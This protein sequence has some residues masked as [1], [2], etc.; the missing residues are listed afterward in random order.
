MYC[1][2][3][4]KRVLNV[5]HARTPE[6]LLTCQALRHLSVAAQACPHQQPQRLVAVVLCWGGPCVSTHA[7]CRPHSE[8]LLEPSQ[9]PP[10]G[11]AACMRRPCHRPDSLHPTLCIVR[12]QLHYT[13]L[14]LL[15]IRPKRT[16]GWN[17]WAWDPKPKNSARKSHGTWRNT[18]HTWQRVVR[19]ANSCATSC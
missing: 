8:K 19:L 16:F 14:H 12:I 6:E 5:A 2:C 17:S 13:S 15:I 3:S 1:N 18:V 7:T 9:K 4:R 11:S 10:L